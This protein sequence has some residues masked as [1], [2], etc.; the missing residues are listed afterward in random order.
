MKTRGGD[1]AAR[2]RARAA[3]VRARAAAP[4]TR[5]RA[6]AGA[7]G[8]GGAVAA[9]RRPAALGAA[10]AAPAAPAPRPPIPTA[11]RLERPREKLR[12]PAAS[13]PA[14]HA[15]DRPPARRAARAAAGAGDRRGAR[16]T[17]AGRPSRCRARTRS[18]LSRQLVV[19]DQRVRARLIHLRDEGTARSL[20]RTRDAVLTTRSLAVEMRSQRGPA[21]GRLQRALT[22]ERGVARG[23]RLDAREP[24]QPAART[25]CWRSTRRLAARSPRCRP[26]PRTASAARA[27]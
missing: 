15:E 25:S 19:A 16:R 26:P 14:A 22:H 1:G 24:A 10:V 18:F 3:D 8:A 5:E 7:R 27:A 2:R 4:A 6:P 13:A 21:V 23:R 11:T 17:P 12:P 9:R 20:A